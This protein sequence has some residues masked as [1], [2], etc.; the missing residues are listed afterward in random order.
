MDLVY[1]AA[2]PSPLGEL[3]LA[4]NE[5]GLGGVWFRDGRYLPGRLGEETGLDHPVLA[6]TAAWLDAYFAG[7]NPDP[8]DVKLAPQGS[9][10]RQLVWEELKKIPYG[11]TTTYGSIAKTLEA[12]LGRRVA[13]QAVGGAVGHNPISILIPCHRVVGSGGSLTGYGGGLWRK[14]Y[15]LALERGGRR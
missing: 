13:A 8:S 4:G 11:Q 3:L 14:E 10:F 6:E 15:L 9:P 1:Y 5:M 7:K 12:T 2:C